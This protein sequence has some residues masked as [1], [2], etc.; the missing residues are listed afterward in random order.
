MSWPAVAH[1][2]EP[3]R[4]AIHFETGTKPVLRIDVESDH[5]ELNIKKKTFKFPFGQQI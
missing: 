3:S 5:K 1:S 2:S 4:L